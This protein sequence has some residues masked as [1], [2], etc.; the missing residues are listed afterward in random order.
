MR[1]HKLEA[2]MKPMLQA[3]LVRPLFVD[4]I[5]E[6]LLSIADVEQLSQSSN[7]WLDM[8]KPYVP[9]LAFARGWRESGLDKTCIK[10]W[11]P[12]YDSFLVIA[13]RCG[14]DEKFLN[15]RISFK[16]ALYDDVLGS[17]RSLL[18]GHSGQSPFNH[19]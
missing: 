13:L 17:L 2:W 1:R 11:L 16:H 19:S 15:H 12:V 5:F 9:T 10:H 4:E 6:R 8:Q 3:L 14:L 18:H 7:A